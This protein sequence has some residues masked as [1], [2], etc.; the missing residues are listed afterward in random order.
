MSDRIYVDGRIQYDSWEDYQG[1]KHNGTKI[2]ANQVQLLGRGSGNNGNLQTE[3]DK[4][5]P[6][7]DDS[8]PFQTLNHK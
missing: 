2:I 1:K 7:D 5:E 3:D 8:F 4:F 6:V